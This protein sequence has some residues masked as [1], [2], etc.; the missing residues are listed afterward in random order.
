MELLFR[1][2]AGNEME[3]PPT[4]RD[5]FNNDD[6]DLVD[7][8]VRESVQNSLDAKEGA[9]PVRVAFK[10][11]NL[12]GDSITSAESLLKIE[13]LSR[14]LKFSGLSFENSGKDGI[15]YLTVEDFGTTG[16]KGA[17]TSLDKKPFSD[18][19]RRMGVSNKSGK[20]LGRW[21]LGKLVFSS[22]SAARVFLGYTVRSDDEGVAYLMGQAVLTTHMDDA[23]VRFD[24]H[25]FYA[26]ES[27]NGF[28]LPETS[29]ETLTSI[30]AIF[31]LERALEPGLSIVV[32]FVNEQVSEEKIIRG[33]VRNYFFPILTGQLTVKVGAV[34]VN[35]ETF[36]SLAQKFGDPRFADGGFAS[37][38]GDVEQ[39]RVSPSPAIELPKNWAKQTG[40][41]FLK[42][43]IESLR[44]K[45]SKGEMIF[46]RAP[47]LLKRKSGEEL[48]SS[49]DLFIRRS[50]SSVAEPLFVRD[51]IV[52]PAETK[53]FRGKDVYAA[54][55]AK[56]KSICEFLGDAENPAHTSWSAS[57]EKLTVAWKNPA[58]RLKE[59]RSVLQKTYNA[60][61]T[62]IEVVDENVLVD[63][64]GIPSEDGT[65]GPGLKGEKENK[66]PSEIPKPDPRKF[67][68]NRLSGGFEIRRGQGLEQHDLPIFI[69]VT[70]AYDV[71]RG[72]PFKKH[73]DL[74]FHLGKKPIK[75]VSSGCSVE[76]EASNSILIEVSDVDFVVSVSGFDVNRDLIVDPVRKS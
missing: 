76:P 46:L 66:P 20:S 41:I 13:K 34:D 59:V 36:P 67:R 48:A 19:W 15:K 44:E 14:H 47:I 49:V 16:L 71:L 7:A 17:T 74:D 73:D 45:M 64:F 68:V 69:K 56:E 18:F 32:P 6:V 51:T 54:L 35:A 70:A 24:S 31:G 12:T 9:Q 50:N 58:E 75:I 8:L 4:Q 30:R 72:N 10:I 40:D 22:A 26:V 65:S 28:Q 21:G 1:E 61:S 29:V 55:V 37:F 2:L 53:Y 25:G 63:I 62:A 33:L 60:L 42:D 52:L 43:Q 23:G 39:A 11:N 57:A 38:I 3:R 27:P 5:Q